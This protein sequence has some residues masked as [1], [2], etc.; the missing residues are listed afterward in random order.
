MNFIVFQMFLEL[1]CLRLNNVLL[2]LAS[3][4]LSV[5]SVL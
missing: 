1:K 5:L 4:F 2:S 3:V